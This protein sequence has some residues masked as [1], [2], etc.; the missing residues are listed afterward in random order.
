VERIGGRDRTA[1]QATAEYVATVLVVGVVL[2]GAAALAVDAAGV[3]ERVV[4]A[5]RTGI[6]MAGGDICRPAEAAA[7]G[8][9]PCLT[10]EDARRQDTTVDIGVVRLGGHGE[11]QIAVQSDGGAVVTR[12]QENEVG[13]TVG[14]GFDLDPPGGR[15]GVE[16]GVSASAVV[17]YR[18]GR[19]WRFP[20][21]RTAAA[22]LSAAMRDEAVQKAREPDMR[23]QSLGGEAG[24]GAGASIAEL[25][26]LGL[27]TSADNAIGL[28]TDGDRRTL[29]LDVGLT[30]PHLAVFVP[31]FPAAAGTRHGIV[32]DVTWEGGELRELVLRSG[33]ANGER[34]DEA[35]ARIDLRDPE[36]RAVAERMLRPGSTAD[37]VRSLALH[38]ARE[39]VVE[40]T[41][42]T[43]SERR[44]G[45][46]VAGRLGLSL[47]LEHQ[48]ITSE[49]RLVDAV[50]WVRGGPP[51]RRFD[52]LGA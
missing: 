26:G 13:G 35:T 33:S 3:A 10:R 18:G 16:A 31:G 45:V 6:C 1:G 15:A 12:L 17:K 43:L 49:R 8:L 24:A 40:L 38:A 21:A 50:A 42:Y 22:F 11:W 27:Q 51:Q 7:A 5:V 4:A 37:D 25:A 47:G 46:G 39:G 29:T 41:G 9:E 32:A 20:D 36:A 19:A 34:V 14:W 44:R 28:R 23:W 48:R 52:C 30:D 2:A